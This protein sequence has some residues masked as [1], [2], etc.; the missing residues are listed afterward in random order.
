MTQTA[1]TFDVTGDLNDQ[2][3]EL[4]QIVLWLTGFVGVPLFALE[5]N[6]N[7]S[8]GLPPSLA[9][10][11]PLVLTIIILRF[12]LKSVAIWVYLAGLM[13]FPAIQ[14]STNG[15]TITGALLLVI[16]VIISSLLQNRRTVFFVM[17]LSVLAALVVTK[18]QL[19]FLPTINYLLVPT[20]ICLV[21]ALVNFANEI[22]IMEM[23]YWAMDIQHKDAT[24]AELFYEQK[25]QLSEA[26]LQVQHANSALEMLNKRLAVAQQK[27]EQASQT[28]TVFLS[29]MSH[30]LRTP[31]NI[32]IGYSSSML[33]MPQM[34]NNV[35]LP[36]IYRPYLK[37]I[38][39]NGH[40]LLGLIND[41][42]DLS[43][44][45]AGKLELHCVPVDLPDLLR[46]TL[47]TSI[48]LLK[49]KPLQLRPDFP[50]HL[51][52]VWADPL[53]VRQ[54]VLNLM[55]NAI[56]FTHTGSVTLSAQ[57]EEDYVRI[58]VTD[59]GIGIPENALN[60]IFDRF[61]KAEH[62]TDKRYGGTGLGLDISKQLSVMHGGDLTVESVVNQ[63][64]TFSFILPIAQPHQIQLVP[65][66]PTT[67]KEEAAKIKIFAE[68]DS[69]VVENKAILLVEDEVN[70]REMI[71]N[72]LEAAGYIVIDANEGAQAMELATG[73]LP[74]LVLLDAYLPGID[75]WDTLSLL[76]ADAETFRIPVIMFTA[77]ENPERAYDLGAALVL[78]KPITPA[79]IIASI[80]SVLTTTPEKE[81]QQR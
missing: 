38:E 74:D 63:G 50:E 67:V 36:E 18:S 79:E 12:Q 14:I 53:R 21:V 5:L 43:K 20:F 33:N 55:S 30:E 9:L 2:R 72:G 44:I 28:K 51:P 42:L 59:T 15:P 71:H 31:L 64:S 3:Q 27:A 46:G 48:G 75:G 60:T 41:I 4:F 76:K 56:K 13:L 57:V 54:I 34:F 47:S 81:R 35:P 19:D 61:Q 68:A 29:N 52:P 62:D 77:A 24:R 70:T 58:A 49:E 6:T 1:Q 26:M 16:P 10:V 11:A 32:V 80:Q 39:D 25:E 65:S 66:Q 37:L 22:S 17:G 23:V 7:Q 69:M 8:K 73:L 40:Y 45:E 78:K